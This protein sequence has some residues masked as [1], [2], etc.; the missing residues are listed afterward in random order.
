MLFIYQVFQ[1]QYA[2]CFSLS[3]DPLLH[4]LLNPWWSKPSFMDRT[5]IF[6]IVLF[7]KESWSLR[8]QSSRELRGPICSF[9]TVLYIY[10]WVCH[11]SCLNLMVFKM[12]TIILNSLDYCDLI[13][14]SF[15]KSFEVPFY[16]VLYKYARVIAIN[17]FLVFQPSIIWIWECYFVLLSPHMELPFVGRN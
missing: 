9:A 13:N 14:E 7:I 8:P 3:F 11:L 2:H 1:A 16:K 15:E 10:S 17:L 6:I 12:N 5:Y 4:L